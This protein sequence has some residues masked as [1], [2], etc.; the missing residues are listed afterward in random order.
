MTLRV[1]GDLG[2]P[3]FWLWPK[4]NCSSFL[5][6]VTY[7]CLMFTSSR[8][9]ANQNQGKRQN[10]LTSPVQSAWV[11][12]FLESSYPKTHPIF[13]GQ[14]LKIPFYLTTG[15][16]CP[17]QY[18]TKCGLPSYKN[19]N[20]IW[21]SKSGDTANNTATGSLHIKS[22]REQKEKFYSCLSLYKR[23]FLGEMSLF[24]SGQK[25]SEEAR[26]LLKMMKKE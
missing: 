17:F 3:I 11:F 13:G 4:T 8:R 16:K 26:V 25:Y 21:L 14:C 1:V 23:L 9:E 6:Q 24:P 10:L 18:F 2:K 20:K 12:P 5:L 22:W 15:K 7:Q 19:D